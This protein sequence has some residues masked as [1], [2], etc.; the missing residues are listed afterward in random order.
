MMYS[1]TEEAVITGDLDR[2]WAVATDVDRWSE[3]DPHEEKSRIDGEFA[4]GTTGWVKPKGAPAGPFTIVAVEPG[5]SWTSEAGIPFGKLRG[6]RTYVPLGDGRVRVAEHVEVHGPMGPLFKLVWE[7][8]M[9][10]DM[11]LTFAALEQ[12]ARRRG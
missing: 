6:H 2:I 7:K 3:W 9:R 12:E 11:P 8:G 1:F 4:A 5:Q 10:A